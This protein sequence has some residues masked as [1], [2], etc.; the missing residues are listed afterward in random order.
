MVKILKKLKI[1]A[2]LVDKQ[3]IMIRLFDFSFYA[4]QL[5]YILPKTKK[6]NIAYIFDLEQKNLHDFLLG[7]II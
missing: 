6:N 1:R 3:N 7:F 4:E 5:F 2:W